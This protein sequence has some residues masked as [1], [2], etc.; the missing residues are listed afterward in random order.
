MTD[1][2]LILASQSASRRAMLSAAGVPFDAVNA[3]VD[4]DAAKAA[5]AHLSA[6]DLADALAE[7]KAL[8]VSQRTPEHLVLGSD[9]VVALDD[10]TL[11]DKPVSRDQAAA[12]LRMMAG[13]RHTLWSAAVI[14][15]GGRAVWRHVEPARMH[16]RP[17]SD[18]FIDTYL[19]AE[20]PAIAGC[21]GCYRIEGPGVQL[22]DKV[23][24]SQFT[25]L[26]LPLMAVLAHLRIRGVLPA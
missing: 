18:A 26:G 6:R 2:R 8:K 1:L 10:G 4:E 22:F 3:G 17:L 15:E 13:K 25:I 14:A 7:L 23:E 20:W 16:V 9:S 21:V 11:L 24:G 12:H 19:D 5:L